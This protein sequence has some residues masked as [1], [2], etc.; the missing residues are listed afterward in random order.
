M[1]FLPEIANF[2]IFFAFSVLLP[3]LT[4]VFPGNTY[5]INDLNT[6]LDL[7][8]AFGEPDLKYSHKYMSGGIINK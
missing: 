8:P 5:S 4:H 1:G 7:R 6:N 3:P 2:V